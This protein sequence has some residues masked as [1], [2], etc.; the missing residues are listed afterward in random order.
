MRGGS[1][2]SLCT[3]GKKKRGE[4]LCFVFCYPFLSYLRVPNF[5]RDSEIPANPYPEDISQRLH[6]LEE[7]V[8]T[9][10]NRVGQ[11]SGNSSSGPSRFWYV[12]TFSSWM[13]V[14]LAVVFMFYYRRNS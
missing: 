2:G 7:R 14:P 3:S 12:V 9:L 8:E 1:G 5:Q 4:Y 11:I 10:E 6:I 13:M